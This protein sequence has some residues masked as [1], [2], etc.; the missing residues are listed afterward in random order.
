MKV[1][2]EYESKTL[3]RNYCHK[4]RKRRRKESASKY[5]QRIKNNKKFKKLRNKKKREYKIN[6]PEKHLLQWA[7]VRAKRMNLEFNITFDDIKIPKLCPALKSPI[8]LNSKNK[9]HSPSLDRVDIK[10]G[11][12]KGNI[13]V[14]SYRANTIKRDSNLVEL[15]GIVKYLENFK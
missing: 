7:K 1:E 8:I 5:Y 15:K 3:A 2:F 10:K 6:N 11:Y 13:A 12:I 4:C 9:D 14:I